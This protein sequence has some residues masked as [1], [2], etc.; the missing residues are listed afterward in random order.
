MIISCCKGDWC[1]PVPHCLRRGQ[2]TPGAGRLPAVPCC[3]LSSCARSLCASCDPLTLCWGW[4]CPRHKSL[5]NLQHVP[6]RQAFRDP[7][8]SV[9]AAGGPSGG[10]RAGVASARPQTPSLR[11]SWL[12]C[13]HAEVVLGATQ[14]QRP[15]AS[16]LNPLS[17]SQEEIVFTVRGKN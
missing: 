8:A 11:S 5:V 9:T 12:V 14:I 13:E 7:L 10:Q 17:I 3:G 2:C 4:D 6:E 15:N 16:L 1:V